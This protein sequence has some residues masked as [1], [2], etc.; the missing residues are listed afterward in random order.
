MA[1]FFEYDPVT[2]IRTD[3][4]FDEETNKVTLYRSADIE[5]VLRYNQ[6][7]R[8]EA[9]TDKGIKESWWRYASIPPIIQ[10]QLRAKGIDLNNQDHLKRAIQEINTNYPY[11]KCTDKEHDGKVKMVF[12]GK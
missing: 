4:E 1:E 9:I 12:G 11:L 6:A 5:A 10:L 3:F 2:G 8:N 7:L